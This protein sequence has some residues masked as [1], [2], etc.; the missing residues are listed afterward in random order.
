M[1]ERETTDDGIVTLRLAHGKASVMDA[2]FLRAF[3]TRIAEAEDAAAIVITGTGSIFS[4]GVDLFRLTDGGAEYVRRFVPLLSDFLLQ[5]FT[6]P[7]PVVAAANGHAVAGGAL[8]VMASDYRLMAEGG[9]R[10]GVPELLVGVPFPASALEIVRYAVAPQHVQPLV[11]TG[12]TLLPDEALAWGVVDEVIPA[13]GLLERAYAVA[14]QLAAVPR[15]TF[16]LTKQYL[17]AETLERI[18]RRAPQNDPAA[19]RV[20][21]DPATHDYIRAYLARTVRK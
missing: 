9:G 20:W 7:V 19:F 2:D 10:I 5:L 6:L 13:E 17:R 11:L 21:E 16:R 4:A 1:I 12:R 15:E 3:Q 14:R 8:T 18:A